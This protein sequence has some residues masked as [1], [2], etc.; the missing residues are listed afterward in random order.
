MSSAG[1]VRPRCR[2]PTGCS[3]V[4]LF[5]SAAAGLTYVLPPTTSKCVQFLRSA[6]STQLNSQMHGSTPRDNG[7][8]VRRPRRGRQRHATHPSLAQAVGTIPVADPA[9]EAG[10]A[11]QRVLINGNTNQD[12]SP[13]TL[14]LLT[15]AFRP[16][17]S[18]FPFQRRSHR[19]VTETRRLPPSAVGSRSRR[20]KRDRRNGQPET[21]VVRVPITRH[22]R[23]DADINTQMHCRRCLLLD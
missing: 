9:S 19:F 2:S 17:G 21:R 18:D 13:T 1:V 11:A 23:C 3:P 14:A 7:E 12:T 22:A 10:N 6:N 15:V 5:K 20:S 4:W 16:P 8:L